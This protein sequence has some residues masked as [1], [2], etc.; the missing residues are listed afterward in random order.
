MSGICAIMRLDGA[1]ATAEALA[2]MLAG[3]AGRGPDG[4]GAFTD[5]PAALGHTLLATTPE[6]LVEPMP[7]RHAPSGCVITADVRLDNRAQLIAAL[8]LDAAGRVIGDGELILQS[9]LRWGTDCPVRLR[10]DFAFVIWDVRRQRL[11][12]ARDKVGMR[13]LI[14]FLD[15]GQL[16]ACATDPDAVL[17]HRDVPRRINE[18][19]IAD[20]VEQLE[21]V[22]HV[23]TFYQDLWR[24]PPGHALVMEG[25]VLK[26][27]RYWQLTPPPI[28]RRASDAAYQEAFLDVFTEAVRVR[29]RSPDPVAAMLSGGMDS[30]SVAAV[31]APLLQQAG[32]S[33]LKTFS[34]IDTD[35]AC[36]ES[37][38]VRDT[39][40]TIPHIAPQLVSL[41]E[42]ESFRDEVARLTREGSDP[43]DGHMAMIRAL[44]LAARRDGVKVMLDGVAGDTTLPTGD[45]IAYHL[46]KGR[47]WQA[48]REARAQERF[49]SGQLNAAKAFRSAVRRTFVPGWI[50]A[51][52]QWRWQEAEVQRAARDSLVS[53]ALAARVDMAE[54][55]RINERHVSVGLGCDSHSQARRMLHPYV[56]VGRERYDRVAGQFGIEPR[57][58]FM[59]ERVLEFCLTLPVEQIHADGWAKLILRRAMAGRLP[60]SVRW[61]M[62]RDHVGWRFTETCTDLDLL[63]ATAVSELG[64][65]VKMRNVPGHRAL[66]CSTDGLVSETDLLYL[67]SWITRSKSNLD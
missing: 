13:Q 7:F 33:P 48:W 10:G 15:Q 42:R 6:A 14:Y 17:R 8:G 21:A 29:L 34:A 65:Y 38:A 60:D 40:C 28:I 3:L 59:D 49:W 9:Y 54:R 56:V 64:S 57:D 41:G 35:P 58:P 67:S 47:V 53:P 4:S 31:A 46:S 24:L 12:C 43:F 27:W 20:F 44:F 50:Q 25:A 63:D 1:L 30:G 23:S 5:G 16:F 36:K 32:A 19:R 22:D 52:R 55:R 66:H 11:F 45:M 18:A 39:L 62:G 37:Q 26:V 2:P 51:P 61:K